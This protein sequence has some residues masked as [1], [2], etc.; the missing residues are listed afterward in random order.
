MNKGLIFSETGRERYTCNSL[1][2]GWSCKRRR[3]PL[4]MP[5][6]VKVGDLAAEHPAMLRLGEME[7]KAACRSL[8]E[9]ASIPIGTLARS[10]QAQS[11]TMGLWAWQPFL[12]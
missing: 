8:L 12:F 1:L 3:S 9:A 6:M 5:H 11:P 4:L 2:Q 7:M 10:G